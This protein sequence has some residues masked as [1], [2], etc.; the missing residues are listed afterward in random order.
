[1]RCVISYQRGPF[2]GLLEFGV[3]SADDPRID[4]ERDR[5]FTNGAVIIR[6]RIL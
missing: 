5:L 3:T 4:L 6:Q 1:M 2:W